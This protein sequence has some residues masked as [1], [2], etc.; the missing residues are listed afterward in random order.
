MEYS[1]EDFGQRLRRIRRAADITQKELSERVGIDSGLIGRYE[2]GAVTPGLNTAYS[3]AVALGVTLDDLAP[4]NP[5][6][7]AA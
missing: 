2:S 7:D 1:K 6:G 5:A 4:V 3:L